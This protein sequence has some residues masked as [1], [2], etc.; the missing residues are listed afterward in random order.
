MGYIY[1]L[2][3]DMLSIIT[4]FFVVVIIIIF[5]NLQCEV[6]RIFKSLQQREQKCLVYWEK[7]EVMLLLLKT[8]TK[9]SF[10]TQIPIIPPF[11]CNCI[12]SHSASDR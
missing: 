10:Q 8:T 6:E 5:I 12:A 3:V 9:V 4:V 7:I 1:T 2:F 11:N